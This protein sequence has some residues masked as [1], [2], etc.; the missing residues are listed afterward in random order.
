MVIGSAWTRDDLRGWMKSQAGLRLFALRTVRTFIKTAGAW[1]ISIPV[2]PGSAE[3]VR[4]NALAEGLVERPCRHIDVLR[5]RLSRER[6]AASFATSDGVCRAQS[7]GDAVILPLHPAKTLR[8]HN[9]DRVA[10]RAG[11]FAA[12]RAVAD[13]DAVNLAIDFIRSRAAKTAAS[14][15]SHR[16]PA[17]ADQGSSAGTLRTAAGS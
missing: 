9:Q 17:F 15:N 13:P 12:E 11:S 7:E 1:F 2:R 3:Q 14:S 16:S 8:R 10:V 6:C 5:V 4:V